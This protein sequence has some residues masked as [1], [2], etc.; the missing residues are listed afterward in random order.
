VIAGVILAGGLARRMGG[1]D[2]ALIHLDGRPLVD[3]VVERLRPQVAAL[4]LNANGDAVRF[5]P[6]SLP[7]IPDPVAGN[8]GPL[9][10]ILAAL[11]WAAPAHEFVLTAPTDCPFLPHDLVARLV[12][13]RDEAQAE[14][15]I[16]V[17]GDRHHPVIALWPV[18]LAAELRAALV[19]QG[20]RKVGDF[21]A[22]H[23]IAPA[24]FPVTPFD[25]FMNVNSPEDI[26]R[27]E[28]VVRA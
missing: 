2:K 16:A 4:A 25:P 14:I 7:V 22:R 1:R 9:A 11:E 6:L 18:R 21:I 28:L 15:A 3:R 17:S 8:P 26:V 10:G 19:E 12:I 23:K 20:V 5:Y 24:A 13:A 27:A